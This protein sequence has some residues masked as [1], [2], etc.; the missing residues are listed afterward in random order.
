MKLIS[1]ETLYPRNTAKSTAGRRHVAK[2]NTPGARA[3]QT[4]AP[5]LARASDSVSPNHQRERHRAQHRNKEDVRRP[6]HEPWHTVGTQQLWVH[7][8]LL[9]SR[10]FGPRVWSRRGHWPVH[11][12]GPV[13]LLNL[14][15]CISKTETAIMPTTYD[16]CKKCI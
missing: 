16:G 14:H 2:K 8:R 11:H 12:L 9:P 5:T 4:S 1:S 7:A 15:S 13:T 6:G 10:N 3:R